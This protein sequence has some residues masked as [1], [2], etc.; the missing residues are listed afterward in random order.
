M[1]RKLTLWV[2]LPLGLAATALST[3]TRQDAPG[4]PRSELERVLET[5]AA[6]D[7]TA[8]EEQ[9]G[10]WYEGTCWKNFEDEGI[11]ADTIDDAVA[12]QLEA[13]RATGLR[14]GRTDRA[15]DFFMLDF[16]SEDRVQLIV[17]F[18]GYENNLIIECSLADLVGDD[19]FRADCTWIIGDLIHGGDDPD[20]EIGGAGEL[21]LRGSEELNVEAEGVIEAATGEDIPVHATLNEALMG[22]G[23][24]KLEVRGEEALLS[25]TLGTVSYDQFKRLVRE[26]PEVTTV[27][28]LDCPGSVNDAVNMHTGRLLREAGLTTRV[29]ADSV[30]ASGAVDLFC[31]GKERVVTRGAQLGVHS[32]SAGPFT[33]ADLPQNHPAHQYQ[34][35]YFRR[36]LGAEVGA[37][38]YFFTL[39]SAPFDGVHFMSEEQLLRYGVATELV[40]G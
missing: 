11:P 35:A 40:D 32:W 12:E 34:L 5:L 25:G 16:E 27:T 33:A 22:A 38:F 23:S 6:G 15:I 4:A 31:M 2:A 8:C 36:A 28:L 24:S 13:I 14:W 20:Y 17:A 29:L 9:G 1:L 26:H 21:T 10:Y 18:D 3:P 30:I 39:T 37:E 19:S 7:R